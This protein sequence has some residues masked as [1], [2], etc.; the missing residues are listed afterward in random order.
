MF[1][2]RSVVWQLVAGL[3]LG[4]ITAP[5]AQAVGWFDDFNDGSATDGN[6]LTWVENPGGFFP[7]T[8]DASSGD[9]VLTPVVDGL[10]DSIVSSLVPVTFTD[11]YIRTQ[12]IVMPD[13]NNPANVGGNL[14][15]TGRIDPDTVSGYIVYFDVSGNLNL[16]LLLGGSGGDIGTT[17]DAPFNAS[18][19]VVLELN[20]VGDQLSAYVWEASDPNGK[21]ATPQVTATDP[22]FTSG[23][24]SIA[25]AEDDDLTYGIFRYVA[26]QDTPFVDVLAGDYNLDGQVDAGDYPVWRDGGSPDDT[27]AGYDLWAA[28]F[29]N[30]GAGSGGA[31]AVPE[32]TGL[33]WILL[34]LSGAACV[35]G[36]KIRQ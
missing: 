10:D 20:I 31:A 7:G 34:A 13:P 2:A 18:T 21:P 25:F 14:V 23:V 8:Y 16:Q 24:S 33:A 12:G 36:R 28:N 11:V 22:T 26:A 27:Q 19:E 30:S 35:S 1:L 15:L 17:Y 29:G 5:A 6:P 3:V 32:P 9:Y 4:L